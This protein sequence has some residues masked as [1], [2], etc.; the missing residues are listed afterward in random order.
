MHELHKDSMT[1]SIGLNLC[2]SEKI[3]SVA[4]QRMGQC[5]RW[6]WSHSVNQDEVGSKGSLKFE[7]V[8]WR[9]ECI[10]EGDTQKCFRREWD[11]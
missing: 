1:V 8:V 11:D 7:T 5:Q 4:V 10:S 6:E 3:I 2:F 9:Q